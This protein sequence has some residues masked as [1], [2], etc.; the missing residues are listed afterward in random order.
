MCNLIFP[1]CLVVLRKRSAGAEKSHILTN[2]TKCFHTA[3][4]M[5]S[6]TVRYVT[7]LVCVP[8]RIYNIY[9]YICIWKD[10]ITILIYFIIPLTSWHS[11]P[12]FVISNMLKKQVLIHFLIW[13]KYG[14][15]LSFFF[16][17]FLWKSF[18]LL[19]GE[20]RFKESLWGGVGLLTQLSIPYLAV[21]GT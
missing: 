6:W 13:V 18:P 7:A 19:T 4:T 14:E 3:V 9:A 21:R 11:I 5:F 12:I 8:L 10:N 2:F 15:D 1:K 16:S 17:F 20:K